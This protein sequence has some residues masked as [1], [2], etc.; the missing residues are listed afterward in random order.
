MWLCDLPGIL[1]W[2]ITAALIPGSHSCG[3]NNRWSILCRLPFFPQV[4]IWT[5]HSLCLWKVRGSHCLKRIRFCL[6]EHCCTLWTVLSVGRGTSAGTAPRLLRV[7]EQH[8]Q[9]RYCCPNLFLHI[10]KLFLCLQKSFLPFIK[11][12]QIN[13]HLRRIFP[14]R[15]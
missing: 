9:C 12:D 6:W 13:W 5:F 3:F 7:T 2:A 8:Q 11:N 1:D 4:G 14:T 10:S 15:C